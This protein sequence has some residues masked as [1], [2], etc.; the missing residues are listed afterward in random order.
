MEDV[1]IFY[2]ISSI[3]RPFS[4]FYVWPFGTFCGN[5]VYFSAFV[6]VAPI[7]IWQP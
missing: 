7:K 6:Y 5:L 2:D 4:I 1:G 3:L